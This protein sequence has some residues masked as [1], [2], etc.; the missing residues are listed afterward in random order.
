MRAERQIAVEILAVEQV[1]SALDLLG[2]HSLV[3]ETRYPR[4]RRLQQHDADRAGQ[5]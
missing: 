5:S 1:A 4:G 2:A 3:E